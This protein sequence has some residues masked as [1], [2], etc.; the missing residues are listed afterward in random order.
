MDRDRMFRGPRMEGGR[1]GGRDDERR[2]WRGEG[3]REGHGEGGPPF[4]A[5]RDRPG[6]PWPGRGG[7]GGPPVGRGDV[8]LALLALLA[9]GPRHGY[10]LIQEIAQRSGGVWQPS[11]GSVYPAL[12]LLEDEGLIRAEQAEAR[13]VFQ[14]TDAGRAYVAEHK[15]ELAGVW[16]AVTGTVDEGV[17]ELFDLFRQVGAAVRQVTLAGSRA[18]ISEARQ[19]L[20]NTR[21]QLY[22]ILADAEPASAGPA[23]ASEPTG[24]QPP[25]S[26]P[27][28][29]EGALH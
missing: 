28:R 23:P 19:L 14:L 27:G 16:G 3:R 5:F 7:H 18:E 21:R 1:H 12:Q 6:W 24:G 2:G 11:P 17:R 15:E 13:R 20:I 9:E 26:E 4:F 22:R 25:A 8:R 29:D 10:Q